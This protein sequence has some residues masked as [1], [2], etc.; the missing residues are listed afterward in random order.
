[1]AIS[2]IINGV[3]QTIDS[4]NKSNP[5]SQSQQ[6]QFKADGFALPAS[7]SADGTGLPSSKVPSYRNSQLKRNIITWF[8]P[9]F[10]IVRM[11]VNPNSISYNHKKLISKDRTKGGYTLQYWGEELSQLN[12]SGT[13]G[14]AGIEGINVLYEIY[15]AEQYAFDGTAL[16]LAANNASQPNL[17]NSLTGTSGDSSSLLGGIVGGVS[18]SVS[19]LLGLDSPNTSLVANNINSLA[20][21]AFTVEMYYN[22]W[23]YRGFFDSMT[24]N[25]RADNFLLEYNMIFNVTQRRGYRMN[26]FPWSKSAIDGPSQYTSPQSFSGSVTPGTNL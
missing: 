19:S 4:L 22:G 3:N 8:V 6:E 7:F 13:T 17:L 21:L 11:Y 5:L 26:Y 25:E 15:R 20:Q 2:D 23:V 14:G 1:M 12:I 10:G 24:I 18:G 16:S 9:E